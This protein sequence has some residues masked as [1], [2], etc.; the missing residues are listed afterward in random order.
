MD[1]SLESFHV[2]GRKQG[3]LVRRRTATE[4]D[5]LTVFRDD[6]DL[7]LARLTLVHP[8]DVRA[9]TSGTFTSAA[10]TVTLTRPTPTTLEV[11]GRSWAVPADVVPRHA[12]PVLLADML[13]GCHTEVELHELVESDPSAPPVAAHF[14]VG[15]PEEVELPGIG[16][17]S[18]GTVTLYRDEV[19]THRY[20][21]D[22][23]E[24]LACDWQGAWSYHV[25]SLTE[26]L[27]GLDDAVVAAVRDFLA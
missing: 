25:D 27:D 10:G 17:R 16:P 22:D 11:G 14:S 21:F 23:H 1:I 6:A 24:V 3:A 5:S 12:G 8:G 4:L 19:P 9:W 15:N 26:L 18:L 13:A 20:W 2:G 7:H